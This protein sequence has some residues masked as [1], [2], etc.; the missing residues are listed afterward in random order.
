MSS[1]N[2]EQRK[3]PGAVSSGS[4]S[5]GVRSPG[6]DARKTFWRSMDELGNTPEF[7]RFVKKEFP[8]LAEE[9]LSSRRSFL[10][11]MS[12]SLGLA[13]MTTLTGCLR[14]PREKIVPFTNR[15]EGRAPGVPVS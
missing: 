10:K 3:S 1:L 6:V 11:I 14:W 2:H 4:V 13:G 15:P 9:I 7:Q 5:S 12:A 8:S